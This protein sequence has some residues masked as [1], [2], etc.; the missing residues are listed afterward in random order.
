MQYVIWLAALAVIAIA[1][2]NQRHQQSMVYLYALWQASEL[3]F[4]FSFFQYLLTG[5]KP[6]T[7]SLAMSN[8]GYGVIGTTRYLIA[9]VFTVVLAKFLYDEKVAATPK[10]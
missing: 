9:V 3:A 10:K 4:Q 1:R 7:V 5:V 6:E 8:L 2:L